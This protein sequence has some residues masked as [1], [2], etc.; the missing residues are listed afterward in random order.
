MVNRIKYIN[1]NDLE[2]MV[3]VEGQFTDKH[4]FYYPSI[5]LVYMKKGKLHIESGSEMRLV[6]RGNFALVDKFTDGLMHKSWTAEEGE[7]HMYAFI[8]QNQFIE[9]VKQRLSQKSVKKP[10]KADAIYILP[11]NLILK[12]LFDSI[13]T[14]VHEAEG[15]D[16]QLVELKTL[17]AMMGILKFHPE[18]HALFQRE[19]SSEKVNLQLLIENNYMYNLS[20]SKLAEMS[21]RSLS[22]FSRDFKSIYHESPHRWIRKRRLL[23]AKELLVN[24]NRKPSEFYLELGFESLAH[25]S[26]AFKKE[27]GVTLTDFR[28]NNHSKIN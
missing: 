23:K 12:G 1:S 20:L 21:G 2:I 24:T 6:E 16:T 17:E 22:T 8:L 3:S 19:N 7:A 5:V 10:D 4:P 27:F 28:K 26:R 18:C 25:F 9:K 15:L 13:V 11:P 14:Y